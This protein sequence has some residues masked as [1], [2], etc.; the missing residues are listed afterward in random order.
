MSVANK[1]YFNNTRSFDWY[2]WNSLFSIG[3]SL[4]KC[5]KGNR[6]IVL[7]DW[8]VSWGEIR[9]SYLIEAKSLSDSFFLSACIKY[10]RV[11][12]DFNLARVAKTG[13]GNSL[14]RNAYEL[15]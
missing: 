6:E 14:E 7:I 13:P 4:G 3:I 15:N 2:Y 5:F 11:A 1:K 12:A 8:L 10:W 9:L